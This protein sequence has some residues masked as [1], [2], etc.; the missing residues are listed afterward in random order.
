M[1][2]P[3]L[4]RW[5]LAVILFSITVLITVGPKGVYDFALGIFFWGP[6]YYEPKDIER[7]DFLRQREMRE[8]HWDPPPPPRDISR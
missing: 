6:R 8:D 3:L 1:G 7:E 4:S 5:A 2:F